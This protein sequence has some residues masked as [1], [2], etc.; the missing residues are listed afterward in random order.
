MTLGK[1]VFSSAVL[2]LIRK[3][4]GNVVNLVVMAFLARILSKEDF[5]LL[6]ISSVFL[7]I[8]NT[9]ATSGIS[10]FLVYYDGDDRDQ[11]LNAAFWLNLLLTLAVVAVVIVSGPW[12]AAF[13][14]NEKIYGLL[15]LLLI[16]FFFEMGSTIPRAML[17]KEFEYKSLVYYTSVA[18]TVVSVGK[19]GAAFTGFGVYSLAL[20]Q[21]IVSPF[22]M[23]IFFFKTKWKPFAY[24]GISHFKSIFNFTKHIIGGRV[25]TKFVNEGDNLIVGKFIGLEGL[26]VYALAFQL[27]NL[28][29]SNVVFLVNDIFL[30]L[31]SKVKG[32]VERLKQLYARMIKFLGFISFPLIT[33]LAIAADPIVYHV[34]GGKWMDAVL[35]FQIL[36]IFALGRSMSSPSSSLF[37]AVGRPDLGF[38]FAL[39]FTPV[40][41]A[42]VFLG[43]QFG[44][45]GVAVSTSLARILGSIVSLY[46]SL[47]LIHLQLP[48]LFKLIK[49]NFLSTLMLMLIFLF[50]WLFISRPVLAHSW[51]LLM[52]I[53]LTVYIHIVLQRIFYYSEVISFFSELKLYFPMKKLHIFLTKIFFL[54]N[55]Y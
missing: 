19:L 39:Y 12:W 46:L 15:L 40:F 25:L 9:L 32:D 47:K 28:I 48:D 55:M 50:S 31:F 33:A 18:M 35:P 4:W 26:G 43:S 5:G 13:Y 2:L 11:K 14:E 53:P 21:A 30:P 54:K 16:S 7:S 24:F 8:I 27:A 20:P 29:T 10:E 49:S 6:A 41:L 36:C 23:I 52:V 34:Y 1:K 42:S 44:I 51:I 17:R 38:K 37:S 3:V 22:L 45:I